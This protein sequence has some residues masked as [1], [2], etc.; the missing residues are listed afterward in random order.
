VKLCNRFE[1]DEYFKPKVSYQIYC[2][3]NCRDIATREKIAERYKATRLQRR[4]NKVRKCRNCEEILSV[5]AEGPLCNFCNIDPKLVTKAL[6]QLKQL[7][8]LGYE[9]RED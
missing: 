3:E 5:Y 8:I 7:G 6:K 1:C 9:Q 4:K 2:S